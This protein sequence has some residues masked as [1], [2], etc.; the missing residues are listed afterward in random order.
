MTEQSP[1]ESDLLDYETALPYYTAV[2]A[3]YLRPDGAASLDG[4]VAKFVAPI[5]AAFVRHRVPE[6]HIE[7]LLWRAWHAVVEAACVPSAVPAALD[8]VH[9][10]LARLL[11][12]VEGQ[13]VLIRDPGSERCRVWGQ[14]VF[15]DLP[16]FGAEM[17]EQCDLVQFGP[18]ATERWP[19]FNAFAARL[20]AAGIDFALYAIWTLRDCLEETSP[21]PA[22]LPAALP[23]FAHCSGLLHSLAHRPGDLPWYSGAPGRLGAL[24]ARSGLT[25]G[26]FTV[27][28]WEFWQ[29]RLEEIATGPGP[30]G[31]LAGRALHHLRAA[32]AE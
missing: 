32:P 15:T 27:A 12:A 21:G 19:A 16:V 25:H 10:R 22:D 1:H 9:E 13:G 3:E 7:G 6:D 29:R 30:A 18:D 26:G 11:N 28:R 23:W 20:T 14:V 17:R 8:R 2:V 5:R 31:Q 24:A 4:A